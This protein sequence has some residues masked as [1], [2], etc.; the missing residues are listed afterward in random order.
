MSKWKPVF[1]MHKL[2]G[3]SIGREAE[4]L[5]EW[6]AWPANDV[7]DE[8][9]AILVFGFNP[10]AARQCAAQLMDINPD[11]VSVAPR[12]SSWVSPRTS[13]PMLEN[14]T[15]RMDRMFTQAI[16]APYNPVSVEKN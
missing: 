8:E 16:G 12:G 9:K 2:F 11:M 5:E 4:G 1:L 7:G 13:R 15:T 6:L 10:I 3:S 14:H